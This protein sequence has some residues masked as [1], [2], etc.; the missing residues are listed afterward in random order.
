MSDIKLINIVSDKV[1]EEVEIQDEKLLED[2]KKEFYRAMLDDL[3]L[4]E[5][6]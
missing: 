3:S 4:Q 5:E 1:Q 2:K 6:G